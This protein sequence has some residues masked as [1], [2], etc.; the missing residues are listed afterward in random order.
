MIRTSFW[1]TKKI[2]PAHASHRRVVPRR[3]LL[4]AGGSC[5][6]KML[7]Q[8]KRFLSFLVGICLV[9]AYPATAGEIHP[10]DSYS[11]PLI[12]HRPTFTTGIGCSPTGDIQSRRAHYKA[13]T[14]RCV[15]TEAGPAL[16]WHF[17]TLDVKHAGL[18]LSE[19]IRRAPQALEFTIRNESAQPVRLR[20]EAQESAWQ[21]GAKVAGLSWRIGE[22]VDVEA[23][24]TRIC[25]FSFDH[26]HWPDR[27]KLRTPAYPLGH[28]VLLAENIQP[29]TPYDLTLSRL[30][31]HYPASPLMRDA[32]V[33]LPP[34]ISAND[35]VSI[36]LQ[37][38]GGESAQVVDVEFRRE[39]WVAWR[40]RLSAGEREQLRSGRCQLERTAPW[41]LPA[42]ELTVGLVADGLRVAGG[43]ECRVQVENSARPQLPQGERRL[44][45]GRPTFFLSGKP[46]VWQ[47]YASYD[48]SPGN[49]GQFGGSG[50]TVFCVPTCAGAH[51]HQNVAAVT[52]LEPDRFD[53]NELDERVFMALA[54][55]PDA[56][57][58][59]RV[60]L[61]LPRFWTD[62]HADDL[63]RVKIDGRPEVW[64]EGG[65]PNVSMAS[66]NWRR[67]QELA[68]RKLLQHC[69]QQVW[70]QRLAGVWLTGEVTEEWFAWG[71]NEKLYC[72][73]SRPNQA[74]FGKWLSL[75]GESPH[76]VPAPEVRN[77][78][79]RDLYADTPEGRLAAGY[80]RFY[81]ELTAQTLS[82]FAAIV[83][84][85]TQRR[86]L[87]GVFFGY[88]IQLAG[89]PRQ[90]LAGHGALRPV[91]DDPN[92]DWLAGIPLHDFRRL[93]DGYSTYISATQSILAAGKLYCNENDLF[94]WLH[95]SIWYTEYDPRDPRGAAYEMH[96]RECANDAVQGAMA[97]KFSLTAS[98]HYDEQLHA[99]FARQREVYTRAMEADRTPVEQIA[100]LV[101]DSSLA[102]TPPASTY[103]H[104]A[105]KMLLFALARTGAPVGV[106]LVSDA[107]R[108]PER[109][110]F[111]VVANATAADPADIAKLRALIAQ[112]GR[113]VLIVGPAGCVDPKRGGW[114]ATAPARLLDL[115]IRVIDEVLPGHLVQLDGK[116]VATIEQLR[117]RAQLEGEG[118]LR[119]AD[120]PG[121][122]AERGLANGGRLIWCGM[123]P[124][125]SELLGRWA[126]E[127]GVHKYAPDGFTLYA[128]RGLVSVT[129]PRAGEAMLRFPSAVAVKDLFD[130][131]QGEG[132]QMACPFAVGQTRLLLVKDLTQQEEA[133]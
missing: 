86:C 131:W 3:P 100:F 104:A 10:D 78:A 113:T 96:R 110:R 59:L 106:W 28:C 74:A 4:R 50:T 105:H 42:G 39:P 124:C 46:F 48:F 12:D 19:P 73:Y 103:L 47:G 52:W 125:S 21:A 82:H 69:K 120:G 87:V 129:A 70:S 63:V 119:Y 123:P 93:A 45:N 68:L 62:Q 37:A 53:F 85:E 15:S 84:D 16:G 64:S 40:V 67:D 54:A 81:D 90:T 49:V 116:P 91:L 7:I 118:L 132:S 133:K 33:S 18:V 36:T 114:D 98:W 72:D 20:L 75:R 130:G 107:D 127:A 83:K 8:S 24:A 88:V 27:D 128:A 65:F 57:V 26:A 76:P 5:G 66:E 102:W 108:L 30:A 109:I 35:P 38:A 115:P 44:H 25:R 11:R 17:Q 71:C 60:S 77:V 89:E 101:D 56:V 41:F 112:G 31:M 122:C 99:E 34:T 61:A 51:V 43:H 58:M 1:K 111:V 94:S 29:Q 126:D 79:G 95:P 32:E 13:H 80:N 14:V 92:I 55:N 2:R 117:P 23:G 121:A 22:P 97:Q 9:F 6:P